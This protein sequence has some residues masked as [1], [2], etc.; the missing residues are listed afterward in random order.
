MQQDRELPGDGDLGLLEAAALGDAE[1]PLPQGR[2]AADLH[3]HHVG[4]FVEQ[5][6][7]G[8]V[9]PFGMRPERFTSPE[10]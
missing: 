2:G 1:A 3:Q 9:A 10:A 6:A 4:R 7:D 8:A 5:R